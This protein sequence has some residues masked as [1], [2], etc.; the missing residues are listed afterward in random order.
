MRR[1]SDDLRLLKLA[2]LLVGVCAALAVAGTAV[3]RASGADF[4]NDNGP[5]RGT[6]EDAFLSQCPTAYVGEAYEVQIPVEESSGCD[7]YIWMEVRLGALPDGLSMTKAGVVSGIPTGAGL[8][9]FWVWLHDLTAAEGGPVWCQFDDK[10]EREFSIPVDP[11]LA[12][13]T[14]SV[15]PAT[16]GQPYTDTLATQD[17]RS[18][19][20]PAGVPVQA[21]WS[22]QSG[23]L[24]PGITLSDSGALA[25]TP[26]TEGSYEFVVKA[27]NGSPFDTKTYTLDVRQPVTTKSPLRSV[28]SAEV[29][30]RFGKTFT[31]TGGSGAYTWTVSAGSLPAGVALDSGSGAITGIPR[32]SGDFQFVLTVA[33][34]EGRSASATASVIVVPRLT[35][36]TFRATAARRGRAFTARLAT[37]GGADP[38]KWRVVHGKLPTGVRFVSRRG[39]FVGT[40]RQIGTFRLVVEARDALRAKA[41]KA[42]VLRVKS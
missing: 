17:V 16:V 13:V 20:P 19:N 33:D 28:P 22:L 14:S 11:G 23:A 40:P 34:S 39:A 27:V 31:A 24:P 35:I 42:V 26:T 5:C 12:I 10:S 37:S 15:K 8:A 6:V 18:L 21:T 2:T 7:P 4:D 41:R 38:L 9:R 36:N 25:G 29:G 3:T 32:A 1:S 30:V